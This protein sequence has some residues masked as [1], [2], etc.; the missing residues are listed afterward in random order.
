MVSAPLQYSLIFPSGFR[1]VSGAGGKCP[2]KKW[3]I[4]IGKA[5][6][7]QHTKVTQYTS[8]IPGLHAAPKCPQQPDPG[9]TYDRHPF[10]DIVEVQD[11]Q[12]LVG[13]GGAHLVDSD[14]F[15]S[16]RAE[17]ETKVPGCSDQGPLIRRLGFVVQLPWARRRDTRG[18]SGPTLSHQ[19]YVPAQE[20]PGG[21]ATGRAQLKPESPSRV[22]EAQAST[23][24]HLRSSLLT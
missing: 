14:G 1:T 5:S 15:G 23:L 2:R 16:T 10:A 8:P 22:G 20:T 4:Q 3:D 17:Y 13:D 21:Q 9:L 24:A 19:L 18:I 6:E 7:L 12:Q 11:G